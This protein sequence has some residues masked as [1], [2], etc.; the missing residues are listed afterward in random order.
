MRCVREIDGGAFVPLVPGAD[1]G[2][3]DGTRHPWRITETWSDADLAAIGVHRVER[4]P[5]PAGWVSRGTVVRRRGG[6]VVE[7]HL[8]ERAP[9]ATVAPKEVIVARLKAK[10]VRPDGLTYLEAAYLALDRDP[11]AWQCWRHQTVHPTHDRTARELIAGIGLDP[12]EI[13]AP[14][15][16]PA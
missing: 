11:A 6:R 4:P 12:D 13:L 16:A 9:P 1:I 15:E 7:E 3:P 10:G 5:V 14:E 8:L 2:M